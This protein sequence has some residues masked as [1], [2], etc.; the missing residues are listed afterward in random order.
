[1]EILVTSA[2]AGEDVD[3]RQHQ[4]AHIALRVV[5]ALL[6]YT[7]SQSGHS[8]GQPTEH[9]NANGTSRVWRGS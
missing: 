5:E 8:L 3:R 1:M 9:I 6:E 2:P 4:V 7:N